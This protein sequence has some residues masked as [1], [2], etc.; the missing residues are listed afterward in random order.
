MELPASIASL[1][2]RPVAV[3]GNGV[4]GKGVAALLR[5]HG[6]W[7][8]VYDHHGGGLVHADFKEKDAARHDLV[9]YSPGFPLAHSWMERARKANCTLVG[10]LDFASLFWGGGIVAITGTNGKTTLTEFLTRAFKRHGTDA[11]AAG[12]IGY[13]LSR[14][15]ELNATARS[16]AIC[17]VSSFQ[18]ERLHYFRPSALLWT[19]FAED[20]LDRYATI[21]AYF[22]AKWNLVG[23]LTR[24]R[25]ILGKSVA[26]WA[27]KLG[28]TLPPFAQ[29]VDSEVEAGLRG[30]LFESP[31]QKENYLVAKAFWQEEGLP[32]AALEETA[33]SFTVGKHRLSRIAEIGQA[34]FWNDSKAT[35][36]HATLNAVATFREPVLWIGGGK[37][38]GGGLKEFAR[39][40]APTIREAFLLGETAQELKGYLE[41]HGCPVTVFPNVEEAVY[42]AF[43]RVDCPAAILLSP[44]FASMDMFTSYAERGIAFERAVLSLKKSSPEPIEF[45]CAQSLEK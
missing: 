25:F 6:I 30:T 13:P 14:L 18:S 11:V 41:E 10:E 22:E 33:E 9:V 15:F 28:Y 16:L 38:K 32:V 40:L 24:P 35:N 20:H 12:N 1:L 45:K 44:G 17:E 39:Q 7:Y 5:A 21:Q 31:P 2:K 4:S 19:N 42:S 36:F 43:R 37:S 8:D 3:L 23:K 34:S 26:V 29:V 27:E